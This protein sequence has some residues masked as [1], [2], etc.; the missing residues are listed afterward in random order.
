MELFSPCFR[1]G[2]PKLIPSPG[3]GERVA[4]SG[5]GKRAR[6][7]VDDFHASERPVPRDAFGKAPRR[8][9]DFDRSEKRAPDRRAAKEPLTFHQPCH[10]A[11]TSNSISSFFELRLRIGRT[12]TF[13]KP[14]SRNIA[15]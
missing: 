10:E 13:A 6:R 7:S 9:R 1:S 4:F 14:Y 2:K 5:S 11:D 15:S 3:I 8:R 12:S